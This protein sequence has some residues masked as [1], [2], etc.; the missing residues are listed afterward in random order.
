MQRY[1]KGFTLIEMMVVIG[2]LTIVTTI[3]VPRFKKCYDDMHLN[4]TL[5]D[6]DSLIQSTRSYYLIMNEMPQDENKGQISTKV[7]WALQPNFLGKTGKD[8]TGN[9]YFITI[10][11]WKGCFYD[12]DFWLEQNDFHPQWTLLFNY[13]DIKSK[14][15]F[16]NKVANRFGPALNNCP[17]NPVT[18]NTYE[19]LNISL[20]EIPKNKKENRYY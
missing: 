5:D 10:R 12:W 11:N 18:Q 2:I 15:L 13:K 16:L 4:K 14:Q 20:V 6:L 3:A 7:A 8:E 9:F 1:E 17:N 19:A